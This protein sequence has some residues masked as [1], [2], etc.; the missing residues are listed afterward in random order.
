MLGIEQHELAA[1]ALEDV[2]DARRCELDDEMAELEG[3]VVAKAPQRARR[4]P[5]PPHSVAIGIRG[6]GRVR[7]ARRAQTQIA[8]GAWQTRRSPLLRGAEACLIV[9]RPSPTSGRTLR[10]ARGEDRCTSASST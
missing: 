7:A 2:A 6:D 5:S 10:E 8:P 3:L 9:R 4:H 1:G